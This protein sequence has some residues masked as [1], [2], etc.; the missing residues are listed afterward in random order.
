MAVIREVMQAEAEKLREMMAD[1]PDEE[2][3]AYAQGPHFIPDVM[4]LSWF[5]FRSNWSRVSSNIG[6]RDCPILYGRSVAL[7]T[8]QRIIFIDFKPA[9]FPR[10][11]LDTI[12]SLML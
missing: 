1:H 12:S 4:S 6:L 3:K 5:M 8:A 2:L 9:R 10:L 7:S 11:P